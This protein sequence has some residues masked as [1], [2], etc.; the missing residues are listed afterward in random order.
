MNSIKVLI[1]FIFFSS[2]SISL[3][4]QGEGGA[5]YRYAFKVDYDKAYDFY[6]GHAVVISGIEKGFID[7]TGTTTIPP[8]YHIIDAYSEGLAS[9]GFINFR[10]MTSRSGYVNEAGKLVIQTRF[11]VTSPFQEGFACV[12]EDSTWGFI[13]RQGNYA[14]PSIY[15]SAHSFSEGFAAIQKNGK[16][17]IIR[18][19]GRYLVS[20]TYSDALGFYEGLCSVKRGDTWGFI[21]Q[22]G[23]LVIPAIYTYAGSFSGGLARVETNG[24]FGIIRKDGSFLIEPQFEMLFNYSHK[25]A[26]FQMNGKWGFIDTKGQI[27]VSPIYDQAG[28]FS[29]NLARVQKDGKWGYIDMAGTLV[30]QP[31]F[32]LG[33]DFREGLARVYQNGKWGFIIYSPA[34]T[35][36]VIYDKPEAAPEELTERKILEGREVRV[37]DKTVTIEL[38]DHKKIDGDIVSLNF[39][40]RWILRNHILSAEPHTLTLQLEAGKRNYLL[41]YANNLGDEPPN[42][43]ALRIYNDQI[44]RTEILN[45]DLGQCDI[46]YFQ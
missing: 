40:G 4:A 5:N 31:E 24:K 1:S 8:T 38:Y 44:K 29:E 15:E 20:P 6:D 30:I 19:D 42:T 7:H 32:E 12:K 45:S 14:I 26:R 16:W 11:E 18:R 17:G 28:D 13:N 36:E 3:A 9:A 46:I 10:T 27:V 21:D 23:A 2:L 41:L 43:M 25:L 39:N 33:Y 34:G 37:Y 35:S 22:T